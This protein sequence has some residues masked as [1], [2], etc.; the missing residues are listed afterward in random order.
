VDLAT[1]GRVASTLSALMREKKLCG[2][3]RIVTEDADAKLLE[4]RMAA[5]S[6]DF[7]FGVAGIGPEGQYRVALQLEGEAPRFVDAQTP[8]QSPE[9]RERNEIYLAEITAK[10]W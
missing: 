2:G 5:E 9:W 8:F 10:G 1:R 3:L 7:V 4:T 6:A